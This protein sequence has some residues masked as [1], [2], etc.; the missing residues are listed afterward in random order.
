MNV[1]TLDLT[2]RYRRGDAALDAVT[3]DFDTGTFGLLGPNGAGKTTL[4]RILA[5]LVAPSSGSVRVGPWQIDRREDR[6]KIR[7]ALGYLPQDLNLYPELTA[8]E[9]VD[10]V[11]LLKGIAD[12]R[13]RRARTAELLEAVG[14]TEAAGERVKSLSGGM[15][16]RVGIAQALVND[17]SLLIVDEPTAG[18]DPQ[19]RVRFRNLLAELAHERT[20][21]LS[22]HIVEDIAQSCRELAV[23]DRGRLAYRGTVAD[24]TA[25]ATGRVW[26]SRTDPDPAATVVA[27]IPSPE[28]TVWR[29]LGPEPGSDATPARPTLED[30][31]LAL[32]TKEVSR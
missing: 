21:L 10:Y 11:A 9:M 4:M 12:H 14:L 26:E 27:S 18:L 24:L 28:G 31:Y 15:R 23:L 20:V 2:K 8:A 5:T 7:A 16:R 13:R 17:P 32:M 30:G 19:E 3:L 6:A 22:T 25:T 29:T 1:R